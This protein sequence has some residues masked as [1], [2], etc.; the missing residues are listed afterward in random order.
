MRIHKLR[1][2]FSDYAKCMRSRNF[3][4]SISHSQ[5][6]YTEHLES[7]HRDG[8]RFGQPTQFS[9]PHLLKTNE[10]AIGQLPSEFADRRNRMIEKIKEHCVKNNKPSRN[11]VISFFSNPILLEFV[12]RK[13]NRFPLNFFFRL[14]YPLP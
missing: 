5:K 9:H 11:I 12:R 7:L 4:T 1:R 6:L 13:L 3:S 14:L 10:L 8:V 2:S